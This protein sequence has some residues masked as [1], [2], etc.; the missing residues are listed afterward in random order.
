[1]NVLTTQSGSTPI[2]S[3]GSGIVLEIPHQYYNPE[4]MTRLGTALSSPQQ[5]ALVRLSQVHW[6]A[7][8]YGE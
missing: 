4:T 5:A 3:Y 6:S 2:G 7:P 1:M 8:I